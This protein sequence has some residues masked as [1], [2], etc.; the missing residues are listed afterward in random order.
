MLEML[1]SVLRDEGLQ[2]AWSKEAI[3]DNPIWK[4]IATH[5]DYGSNGDQMRWIFQLQLRNGDSWFFVDCEIEKEDNEWTKGT[6]LICRPYIHQGETWSFDCKLQD[7]Q[8][9]ATFKKSYP[10][11]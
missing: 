1:R 10:T 9:I 8:V 4:S 7:D 11:P 3:P 2:T 6:C 5:R